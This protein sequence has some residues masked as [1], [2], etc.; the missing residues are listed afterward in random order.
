MPEREKR[1][2]GRGRAKRPRTEGPPRDV[3]QSQGFRS[4]TQPS[5]VSPTQFF[6]T[7]L[8]TSPPVRS[9]S[10]IASAPGQPSE[11]P[12]SPASRAPPGKVAIPALRPPQSSEPSGKGSRKGRTSHA[13]NHCRKAKA[14]CTGEQPCQ[15]CRNANIPCVYG[16]GKRVKDR[17]CVPCSQPGLRLTFHRRMTNLSR[18]SNSLYQHSSNVADALSQIQHNANLSMDEIRAAIDHILSMV[19]KKLYT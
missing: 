15:R 12:Q 13:C 9:L 17:K 14:G 7:V 1:G 6:E 4:S 18:K 16:D 8:S 5:N 3:P 19:G 10:A 2:R 11:Q